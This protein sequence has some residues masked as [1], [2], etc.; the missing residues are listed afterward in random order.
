MASATKTPLTAA[1]KLRGLYML[2]LVDSDLDGI[3]IMKGELPMEVSDLEDEIAG[4]GT[5][6]EKMTAQIA[7][8]DGEVS[9]HNDNIKNAELLITKYQT[10]MDNV[11]NNREYEAL[12]KEIEMQHLEIKLSEKRIREFNAQLEQKRKTL[13]NTQTRSA[14]KTENLEAKKE[15]LGRIIE[16]TVK[17]EEK[18]MRKTTRERKKIEDRLLVAYDRVRTSYRNGLAV[19]TVQRNACGGCFNLVPPQLRLEI[20]QRQKIQAC[21]HC[22]RILV[23]DDILNPEGDPA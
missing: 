23:D 11:K 7:E 12:S 13:E 5:R 2:Q 15:E 19:V 9:N 3:N 8:L 17:E 4:L 1:Q 16:K 22:G 18:L 21:E 20:G 10:Q 14:A 6:I